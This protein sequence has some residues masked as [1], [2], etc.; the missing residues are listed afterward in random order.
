MLR[1]GHLRFRAFAAP[2][3]KEQGQA[4]Q[5]TGPEQ[6][7]GIAITQ[8]VRLPYD[9]II[10]QSEGLMLCIGED[11]AGEQQH[12]GGGPAAA[13]TV[14]IRTVLFMLIPVVHGC[15]CLLGGGQKEFVEVFRPGHAD[16][17]TIFA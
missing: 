2:R 12:S 6:E 1:Q 3:H 15:Q 13:I 9:G 7:I 8:C 4:A 16:L 10:Q 17:E 14:M 11:R 5:E